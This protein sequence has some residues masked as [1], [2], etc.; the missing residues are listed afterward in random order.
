LN[1][2]STYDGRIWTTGAA[3][4]STDATSWRS[5]R[6]RTG[7]VGSITLD[8]T[9]PLVAWVT[10]ETY[11]STGQLGHVFK[12]TV[13]AGT[14]AI[15]GVRMDGTGSAV[16]PDIPTHSI[17]IDPDNTQHMYAATDLG[18]FVTLD[19]GQTWYQEN[20]GF[21]NVTTE[22]VEIKTATD[23]KYLYAFTHGRSA[24]RLKLN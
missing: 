4:T 20:A 7:Q 3:S 18:V 17:A 6:P 19:G 11:N 12:M 21:A 22:Y 23:G 15:S 24:W 14:G 10:Y 8:P 16:I 1:G 2:N 13:D 5:S 9:N